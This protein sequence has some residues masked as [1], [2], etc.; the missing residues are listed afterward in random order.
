MDNKS[1]NFVKVWGAILRGGNRYYTYFDDV[2]ASLN[3]FQKN[4]NWLITDFKAYPQYLTYR[5]KLYSNNQYAWLSGDELTEMVYGEK[6]Q[7][8]W[9]VL[10][11]FDKNYEL[12]EILKY[13]Y[14]GADGYKGFWEPELS[15]QHP[16]ASVELVAFDSGATLFFTK[17]YKMY[18]EYMKS[19]PEAKD[20]QKFNT[21]I[22]DS[23]EYFEYWKKQES[24]Q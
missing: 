13:P 9:A 6:F 15:I 4:Y 17:D 2:F 21:K 23:E 19:N 14:P 20:L 24:N 18:L 8:V 3:D 11:G 7:W 16:F 5:N 1:L 12:E 22:D 10:S